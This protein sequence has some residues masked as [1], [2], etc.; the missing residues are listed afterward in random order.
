MRSEVA[1]SEGREATARVLAL[2]ENLDT[3]RVAELHCK[4]HKHVE[5]VDD[6]DSL[7]MLTQLRVSSV[8]DGK[9]LAT[10]SHYRV[11]AVNDDDAD[12]PTPE[13]TVW[14]VETTVVAHWSLNAPEVTERDAQCFAIGQG[15]LACH[16]YARE[17][18]QSATSRMNYPPAT[19]G[20]F[21]NPWFSDAAVVMD[22]PE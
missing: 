6:V 10:V 21:F 17:V 13:N 12:E 1:A 15:A 2:V 3:V 22:V 8:L 9:D 14:T 18:I 11:A 20:L 19:I 16:P 4:A 5:D 7:T